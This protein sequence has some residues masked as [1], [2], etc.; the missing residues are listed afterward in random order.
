MNII[1]SFQAFNVLHKSS[2][3]RD[4]EWKFSLAAYQVSCLYLAWQSFVF[5]VPEVFLNRFKIL[6][7]F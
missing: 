2:E 5:Q 1:S 6:F 3:C 7:I 4:S